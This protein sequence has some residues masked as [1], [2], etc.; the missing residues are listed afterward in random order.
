MRCKFDHD[1]PPEKVMVSTGNPTQPRPFHCF[2]CQETQKITNKEE[3]WE[4][5]AIA[6]EKPFYYAK[7]CF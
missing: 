5:L 1:H 3:Y 4:P 7:C 6:E 2:C